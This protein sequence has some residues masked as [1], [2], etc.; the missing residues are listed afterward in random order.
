MRVDF[1]IWV[2]YQVCLYYLLMPLRILLA[3]F[4]FFMWRPPIKITPVL[5]T[6]QTEYLLQRPE[7]IEN[8][9]NVLGGDQA[10]FI[11][12]AIGVN[13]QEGDDRILF[14]YVSEDGR[15]S[16]FMDRKEGQF[17]GD[18]FAGWLYGITHLPSLTQDQIN[19]LEKVFQVSVYQKPYFQFKGY[20]ENP[21]RGYL[22]R[23]WFIPH[24]FLPI[25]TFS[26]FLHRITH[27]KTYLFWYYF[28]VVLSMPFIWFVP[29]WSI[30]TRRFFWVSFYN[31]HSNCIY[32]DILIRLGSCLGERI[33]DIVS[34]KHIYNPEIIAFRILHFGGSD[35]GYVD[36]CLADLKRDNAPLDGFEEKEFIHLKGFKKIKLYTSPLPA[37]YRKNMYRWEKNFFTK[38]EGSTTWV[39]HYH[40]SKLVYNITNRRV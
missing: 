10:K 28:F 27:K 20:E 16:R 22:F 8:T 14:S 6:P 33:L 36:Y 11:G 7:P 12:L 32:A 2:I 39:D 5:P 40:L 24:M 9:A 26:L 17:S 34:S 1:I 38:Q 30:W 18:M 13:P 21:N 15:L 29:D 37:C 25:L 19:L 3:V 35:N 4:V 31:A 23:F